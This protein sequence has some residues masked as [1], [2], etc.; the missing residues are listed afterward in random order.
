[1]EPGCALLVC[2]RCGLLLTRIRA[3]TPR[4]LVARPASG[5]RSFGVRRR[6]CARQGRTHPG[7]RAGARLHA[8][9][10]EPSPP[11][12]AAGATEACGLPRA[13]PWGDGLL[14]AGRRSR[15]VDCGR[16]SPGPRAAECGLPPGGGPPPPASSLQPRPPGAARSLG[17]ATP[18]CRVE[19]R[20]PRPGWA[21]RLPDECVLAA[22]V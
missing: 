4:S 8:G 7:R 6:L 5:S 20:L 1:M 17:R 13:G 18:A 21:E 12:P 16:A 3:R 19:A 22:G 15:G 9:P 10:E 14:A 11:P 2:N